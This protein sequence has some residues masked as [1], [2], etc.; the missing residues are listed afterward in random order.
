MYRSNEIIEIAVGEAAEIFDGPHATPV[1]QDTGPVFLGISNLSNGRLNLEELEHVSEEIFN[2]WTRRILPKEGDLVFSYET[3]LGEA[4]LI[5]KDLRCCL[6]RRMGLLRPREERVY[7]R[8]LLYAYL[9]PYFQGVLRDRTIPGSTVDRIPLNRLG[10]FPIRIHADLDDQRRIAAV[11]G[12]LDDKIELNRRMNETLEEMARTI[13]R[14]W[15]VDFDPVR[16]KARGGDPVK[17]L[18]I[19][20]EI[21]ALFPDSFEDSELGEIPK[22]WCIR[23]ISDVCEIVG[24]GTPSTSE[25]TYWDG[26]FAWA[27][28]RDLSRLDSPVILS[29]ERTVTREG[30]RKISSGLL[31]VGSV[32]MSSRAPIG[33]LAVT[34][35]PVA[36]NQGFIALKPTDGP[37]SEY[38]INWCAQNMDAIKDRANGSTFMEISKANFRP[39]LLA[40]PGRY[41]FNAFKKIVGPI[42]DLI[43]SNSI[44]SVKLA[45]IRDYLL[46]QLLSGSIRIEPLES[47][48]VKT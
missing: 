22:G 46:P 31:P 29:T 16:I 15:F 13:F 25:P 3:R 41:V 36:I 48:N 19:S 37:G 47:V 23:A 34:K 1:K 10:N 5:P 38:L 26:E 39:M 7:N 44:E 28:P 35:V 6:G 21:A 11:L 40:D 17:E 43:A 18:G 45:E 14:S 9:S 42:Y 30:L 12:A 32:L 8:Y 2:I 27:T 24:G 4:A 20:P 33:Y